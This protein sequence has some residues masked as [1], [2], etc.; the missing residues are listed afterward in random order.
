MF[1]RPSS[2]S[3][4]TRKPAMGGHNRVSYACRWR[5]RS[6]GTR[7]LQQIPEWAAVLAGI[8]GACPKRAVEDAVASE[9]AHTQRTDTA[10]KSRSE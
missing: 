9:E 7:K 10:A 5:L 4:T 8:E 1:G 3:L 6:C 2:P